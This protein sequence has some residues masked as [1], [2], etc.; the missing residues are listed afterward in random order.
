VRYCPAWNTGRVAI[1]TTAVRTPIGPHA[2]EH[3]ACKGSNPPGMPNDFCPR[4][5][6]LPNISDRDGICYPRRRTA[7]RWGSD[8]RVGPKLRGPSGPPNGW[9]GPGRGTRLPDERLSLNTL[10]KPREYMRSALLDL[11]P[12]MPATAC[13]ERNEVERY[14]R[15][16]ST[17][18]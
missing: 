18:Y 11:T 6:P 13:H 4:M 14:S 16:N 5:D 8:S 1:S 2:S 3:I 12:L 9:V 7:R 15:S 17:M 10:T